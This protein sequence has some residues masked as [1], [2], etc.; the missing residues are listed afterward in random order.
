[1]N[2]PLYHLICVCFLGEHKRCGLVVV[3]EVHREHTVGVEQFFGFA[4][5]INFHRGPISEFLFSPQP[6]S[7][8]I[9][10]NNAIIKTAHTDFFIIT[11]QSHS[12]KTF[13]H[14]LQC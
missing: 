3:I 5:V 13:Y 12:V 11:T 10:A 1:M 14:L 9:A 4:A 8:S 6:A 2:L 7:V